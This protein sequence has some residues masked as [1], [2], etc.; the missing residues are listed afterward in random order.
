MNDLCICFIHFRYIFRNGIYIKFILL[1][2]DFKE[3]AGP[4]ASAT[5]VARWVR[6]EWKSHE[7]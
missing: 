7:N 2:S 3:M 4:A 1:I 5:N 6:L